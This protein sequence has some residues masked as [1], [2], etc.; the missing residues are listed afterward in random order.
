M[1][2]KLIMIEGIPG[3]GK[4]T[5]AGRIADF[6]ISRGLKTNLYNEGG[7]HPTDLA[8]NACVPVEFLDNVLA[9]YKSFIDEINKNIHI[10]DDYAIISYTQVQTDDNSFF[11]EMEMYEIYDKR[12]PLDVFNKLQFKRWSS[13]GRK[14]KEKDELT[15]FECV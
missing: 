4:S 9:P 3:S 5:F 10:E 8:W 12:V 6:Y 1:K 13:F 11:K 15:V 14:S 7:F 2:T